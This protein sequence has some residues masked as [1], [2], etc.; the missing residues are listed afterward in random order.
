MTVGVVVKV[1]DGLVLA[2]DS[3]TTIPLQDGG[4]Q[5]YNSA[6]KVF[7]LHRQLPVAAMT[8]GLGSIGSASIATLAKDLRRRLMG[9][10]P[11]C[12]S[13]SLDPQSYTIE[14]VAELLIKHFYDELYS[15]VFAEQAP[16]ASLGMLVAGYSSGSGLA[17]AWHVEI[18]DPQVRPTPQL[19]VPE[20]ACGWTAYAQP[21]ANERLWT[22]IDPVTLAALRDGLTADE[23]DKVVQIIQR[24]GTVRSP[25]VPS[26]PLADAIDLAKFMVDATSAYTHFLLGP[27]TVGGPTEVASMS[28]HEG[29]RWISR[30]HY[31]DASVNPR[32][33]G[34]EC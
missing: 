26:M 7:H 6:N 17:E 5:V 31:Y 32:E 13:W 28:R 29:F 3:A 11:A 9:Q 23:F 27:N 22:G 21:E 33:P 4:A 14:E 18:S 30:K 8:W 19:A 34:H 2:T 16:G 1:W 10:D 25:A 20:D 15:Q 24:S 12:V